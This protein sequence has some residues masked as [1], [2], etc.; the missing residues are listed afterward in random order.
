[1]VSL[2]LYLL[3][4]ILDYCFRLV[5]GQLLPRFY[6]SAFGVDLEL[7]YADGRAE[8]AP[9]GPVEY[10]EYTSQRECDQWPGKTETD[11]LQPFLAGI[12]A[13]TLFWVGV[14]YIT[15]VLP[16]KHCLFASIEHI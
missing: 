15:T 11:C 7:C 6:R 10:A 3:L 5:A 14:R 2:A 9:V 1:M 16:G 8:A 12:F 13:G 4:A